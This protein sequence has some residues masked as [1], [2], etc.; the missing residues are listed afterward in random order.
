M[1]EDVK[2][3]DAC[4]MSSKARP[5][6]PLNDS[7]IHR[8]EVYLTSIPNVRNTYNYIVA[9]VRNHCKDGRKDLQ[10]TVYEKIWNW[11]SQEQL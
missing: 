3:E 4:K 9:Q 2:T 6:Q 10:Y 11:V 1:N 7:R 8:Y 5:F